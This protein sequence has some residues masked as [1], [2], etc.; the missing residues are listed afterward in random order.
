MERVARYIK[1]N[2]DEKEKLTIEQIANNT[3]L[4]EANITNNFFPY[5]GYSVKS[6]IVKCQTDRFKSRLLNIDY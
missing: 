3:E 2:I 1:Q 5:T 6:Y 4:Q